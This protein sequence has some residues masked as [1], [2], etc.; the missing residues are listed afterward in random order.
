MQR[1]RGQL[2]FK[3][4]AINSVNQQAKEPTV[5]KKFECTHD[6]CTSAY[7]RRT[8]LNDHLEQV[9]GLQIERVRVQKRYNCPFCKHDRFRTVSLLLAHCEKDHDAKLGTVLTYFALMCH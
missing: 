6:G 5:L 4:V 8:K 2:C 1:N 7:S 3:Q 9:H